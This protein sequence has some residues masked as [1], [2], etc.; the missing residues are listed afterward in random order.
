MTLIH[1]ALA[2]GLVFLKLN[3]LLLVLFFGIFDTRQAMSLETS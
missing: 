1:I 3:T 2:N